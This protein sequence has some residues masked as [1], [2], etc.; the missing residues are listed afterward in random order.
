M[1]SSIVVKQMSVRTILNLSF[2]NAHLVVELTRGI[3]F[4]ENTCLE[5]FNSVHTEIKAKTI[6]GL[7]LASKVNYKSCFE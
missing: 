2:G 5:T 7:L 6:M 1:T 3:L 4:I